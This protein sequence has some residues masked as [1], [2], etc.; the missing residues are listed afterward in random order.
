MLISRLGTGD[1]HRRV[2]HQ[3]GTAEPVA[4]VSAD[5][6]PPPHPASYAVAW[7]NQCRRIIS[8]GR[9]SV[10][11][12]VYATSV[13]DAAEP[14]G[15]HLRRRRFKQ[16]EIDRKCLSVCVVPSFRRTAATAPH[17]DDRWPA[18]GRTP[19]LSVRNAHDGADTAQLTCAAT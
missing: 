9:M 19:Q 15:T 4:P 5:F 1:G 8:R 16:Y 3:G 11:A 18:S 2:T 17:T 6:A 12:S 7:E 13:A 14:A 10:V